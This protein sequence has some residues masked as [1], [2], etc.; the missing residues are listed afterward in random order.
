MTV[1]ADGV[2]VKILSH[3]AQGT[4]AGIKKVGK[5]VPEKDR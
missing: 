2:F 1:K 3:P 4:S 5:A